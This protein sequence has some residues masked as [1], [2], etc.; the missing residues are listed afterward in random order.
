MFSASA[1]PSKLNRDIF[2]FTAIK[3][4]SLWCIFF[5][6]VFFFFFI[7]LKLKNIVDYLVPSPLPA[8]KI[9]MCRKCISGRS[10]CFFDAIV[11]IFLAQRF[12]FLLSI[13][14]LS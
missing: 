8:F 2:N 5:F 7:K 10:N 3:E 13:L 11:R 4:A 1:D 12:D 9:S 14:K 6:G